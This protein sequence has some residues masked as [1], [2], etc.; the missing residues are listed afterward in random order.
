M[1]AVNPVIATRRLCL[2]PFTGQDTDAIFAIYSDEQTNR[3]LPWFPAKMRADAECIFEERYARAGDGDGYALAVCFEDKPI[4]YVHLDGKPPYDLG[5]ALLPAW[6]G[7]GLAAEACSA[8]LRHACAE[9]IPYVTATHDVK[10][11][12]SGRVMQKL[13]MRYCYTYEEFWRPKDIPVLFRLYQISFKAAPVWRG[14]WDAARRR[15]IE[16]GLS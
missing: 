7:K 1:P 10:N 11:P 6:Q 2:R 15:Y 12:A 5:Y 16:R 13:G 9:G 3:F 8:V 4:G 14:Y